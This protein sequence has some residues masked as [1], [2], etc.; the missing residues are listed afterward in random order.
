MPDA[1]ICRTDPYA[2]HMPLA[3]DCRLFAPNHVFILP[4]LLEANRMQ[5]VG[6]YAMGGSL[7]KITAL[8]AIL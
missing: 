4:A 8:A 3:A 1:W 6:Q 5:D 7:G 2:K